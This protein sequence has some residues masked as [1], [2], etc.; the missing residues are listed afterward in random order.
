MRCPNIV[1][2][3]GV[4]DFYSDRI[5]RVDI[6]PAIAETCKILCSKGYTTVASCEG[7]FERGDGKTA[8]GYIWLNGL[9]KIETPK[10]VYWNLND[11][12]FS[13][14]WRPR[15]Q[16]GLDRIHKELL[17]WARAL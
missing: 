4:Q 15:T 14:R 7:H 13:I 8:S 2:I 10:G 3:P 1:D 16:E 11:G 6:D 5:G 12:K 17:E 9:P